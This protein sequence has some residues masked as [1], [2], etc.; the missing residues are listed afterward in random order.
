MML[1]YYGLPI[2]KPVRYWGVDP[3]SGAYNVFPVGGSPID[4]RRTG[5]WL[6][7]AD[8]N[9]EISLAGSIP[10]LVPSP[11]GRCLVSLIFQAP[12]WILKDVCM[13]PIS[14]N[15]NLYRLDPTQAEL[16]TFALPG[17]GY[18]IV[19][20]ADYLWL[21]SNT[22]IMRL[23]ISSNS[24]TTWSLPVGSSPLGLAVD[25]LGNLWYADDS[26][27]VI[28]Q[29]DPNT[30]QLTSYAIPNGGPRE[31]LPSNLAS[32]GIQPSKAPPISV[33]LDPLA[34]S[35]T[36]LIRPFRAQPSIPSATPSHHPVRTHSTSPPVI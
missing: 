35:Y 17:T 22:V 10:A 11:Y 18:Y 28:A 33:R 16:C 14:T 20:D 31:W 2:L 5:D 26:K 12:T 3:S 4:A 21:A 19:R 27:V 6:W 23:Q 36:V 30:N 25:A 24:L 34:A 29:L 8:F 15:P 32:S 7:W 13:L 1:A 9:N